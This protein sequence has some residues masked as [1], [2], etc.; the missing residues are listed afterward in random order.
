MKKFPRR[1]GRFKEVVFVFEELIKNQN[2]FFSNL[3]K[4]NITLIKI[5]FKFNS[6]SNQLDEYSHTLKSTFSTNQAKSFQVDEAI[7]NIWKNL[8]QK[9]NQDLVRLH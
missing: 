4:I 7:K 3:F 9:G 5:Q 1:P 2:H 6:N 8:K